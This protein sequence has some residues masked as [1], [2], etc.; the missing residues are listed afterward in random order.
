MNVDPRFSDKTNLVSVAMYYTNQND[1]KTVHRKIVT[2]CQ[3]HIISPM[4]IWQC[5]LIHFKQFMF[6]FQ[7]WQKLSVIKLKRESMFFY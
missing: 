1:K 5:Q 6:S 4:N 2:K 3:N 7:T